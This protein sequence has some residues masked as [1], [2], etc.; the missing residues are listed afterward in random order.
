MFKHYNVLSTLILTCGMHKEYLLQLLALAYA[1]CNSLFID[2]TGQVIF[3]V[4]FL[5][6]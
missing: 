6:P 1:I 5:A 3:T 4:F 2:L